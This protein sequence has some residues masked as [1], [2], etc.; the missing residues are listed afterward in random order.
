MYWY[1]VKFEDF[2]F[3][4]RCGYHTINYFGNGYFNSSG[5]KYVFE[6]ILL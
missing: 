1:S 6:A 4:S 2:S 5:K 3:I